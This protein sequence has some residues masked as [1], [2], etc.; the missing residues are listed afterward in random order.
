MIHPNRGSEAP[1]RGIPISRVRAEGY[2]FTDLWGEKEIL[3]VFEG[4]FSGKKGEKRDRKGFRTDPPP[5]VWP[6]S[7]TLCVTV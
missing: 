3:T 1:P 7:P 6:P 5:G 4:V 2:I